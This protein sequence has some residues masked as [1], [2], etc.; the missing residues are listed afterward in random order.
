MNI[1]LCL[2]G[3]FNSL[4]DPQ[5]LGIDGYNHLQRRFFSQLQDDDHVYVFIHSW[6]PHR[7]VQLYELYKPTAIT[8]QPQKSFDNVV[9]ANGLDRIS[10]CPRTPHHVFSHLYSMQ[11]VMRL[12]RDS[13]IEFD[14]ILRCRFDVGRINRNPNRTPVQCLTFVRETASLPSIHMAD[15]ELLDQGPGDMWFYGGSEAM[16]HLCDIYDSAREEMTLNTDFAQFA[17][18]MENNLG[19][20]SNSIRYLKWFF[21]KRGLWDT[22]TLVPVEF[23]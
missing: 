14:C 1:G 11:Q 21:I 5:S 3:Y 20:V 8:L 7:L 18:E 19:D 2:H 23:E 13:G 22:K 10:G 9:R 12:C 16:F 6:E 15:W 17:Y 4:H